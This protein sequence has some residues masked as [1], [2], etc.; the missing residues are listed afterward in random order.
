MPTNA[1]PVALVTGASRG[2]GRGIA[3]A[4]ARVG[5]DVLVNYATRADAAEAVKIE[6]EA[7]GR[8]AVTF[9][10]NVGDSRDRQALVDFTLR[11][12]GRIDLLVNNAGIPVRQRGDLLEATEESYEEVMNTNLKGPYFLTQRVAKEMVRLKQEGII[13]QARIVFVTSIS[14]YTASTSRGEYCLSKA[15]LSMA[16]ALYA[17]RLAEF[18]IPVFEVR[19]GIIAT[20]MTAPVKEKYDRLIAEGL[21]PQRRWGTPEDVGKAV[22]ALATGAFDYSTGQVIEV[23]GGFALRRL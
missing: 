14:A 13:P 10:A 23:G 7:L 16:V 17:D 4:L 6:I 22:A 9:R 19:P 2:I 20:D 21:L 18:D 5:Y 11:T 3:L 12:F 1:A 15:A 8:R